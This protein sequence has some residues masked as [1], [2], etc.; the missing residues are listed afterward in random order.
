MTETTNLWADLDYAIEIAIED[1]RRTDSII[2][3]GTDIPL[4]D[5][6]QHLQKVMYGT[7]YVLTEDGRGEPMLDVW[8][9]E[10]GSWRIHIGP[11]I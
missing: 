9:A 1:S 4:P 6:Q 3:V 5:V 10:E 11:G 8:D 2:Q 7:D